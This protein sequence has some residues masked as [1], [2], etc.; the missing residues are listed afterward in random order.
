MISKDVRVRSLLLTLFLVILIAAGV[1]FL[2]DRAVTTSD[3][4][5][6]VVTQDEN[7]VKQHFDRAVTRLRNRDYLQAIN[8][9]RA[10]LEQSPFLPEAYI[11][12]GFAQIELE[13]YDAAV[14]SFETAIELRPGQANAYWGLAVSLEGLCNIPGAMGAMR[15]YIHLA[16]TDDP[17]L[18]K[19]NAALWEW[20]Q[21]KTASINDSMGVIDCD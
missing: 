15:T 9:F 21:L 2:P 18:V 13:Q 16:D 4:L 14:Q 8:G 3:G 10:V 12:I 6:A 19:A 11:N 20:E 17:F 7:H 1:Q 5:T